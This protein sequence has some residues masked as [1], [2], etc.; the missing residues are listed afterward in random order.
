MNKKIETNSYIILYCL[1][2][3][4][5][6]KGFQDTLDCKACNAP[7]INIGW[8]ERMRLADEE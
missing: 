1:D 3:K 6:L 7:L 8:Y 2:C 4:T 5:A